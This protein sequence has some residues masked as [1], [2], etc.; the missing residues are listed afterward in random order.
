MSYEKILSENIQLKNIIGNLPGYI[1]WKN[2]K[3]TYLGCNNCFLQIAGLNHIDDVIGKS[4]KDFSWAS[5]EK[6][7]RE[8]DEQAMMFGSH[9]FEETVILPNGEIFTYTVVKSP[10]YD[11]QKNII[12]IIGTSLDISHQKKLEQELKEAKEK[13]EAASKAKSEFIANMSHDVKT[14][15]AGIIGIGELLSSPKLHEQHT[16]FAHSIVQAGKQLM[17]FFDHCLEMAKSEQIDITLLKEYFHLKTLV[18]E[19]EV[20]FQPAIQNKN[21]GFDAV[22]DAAIPEYVLGN[23]AAIYRILLNLLGNAIKFTKSGFIRIHLR[24]GE[25]ST[26][27]KA[28]IKLIVE[29]TGIGIPKSKQKL[30]FERFTRL[31]P[32]YEGIYEG[33]GIGLHVVDTL[34][35]A[36]QGEIKLI[37][38]KGK[39]SQF[40]VVFPLEIPLL[41]ENEYQEHLPIQSKEKDTLAQQKISIKSINFNSALQETLNKKPRVLFIEDHPMAQKVGEMLLE[42]LSQSLEMANCAQQVLELFEPNKY[43]LIFMDLGLPDGDGISLTKKI[44][45]IEE[46]SSF[47]VPI[48]ALTAHASEE[49]ILNCIKAGMQDVFHKPLSQEKIE[50][51]IKRYVFK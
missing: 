34:V 47:R 25:K 29:D 38:K 11:G 44:R 19:I 46:G 51:V 16:D 23:R 50:T 9:S 43:D 5:Q 30:I 49:I 27:R 3:G 45:T 40:L 26:E 22:Y 41:K 1:Y 4:D 13:A 33:T 48:I 14:P 18:Q 39:G 20:L 6:I 2:K 37:S 12:G 42:P 32:S 28:I 24:L 10:L 21:L 17:S 31:T 8:H 36:M 7:L 35:K 15:L